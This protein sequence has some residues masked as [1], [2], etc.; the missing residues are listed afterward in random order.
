MRPLGEKLRFWGIITGGLGA[1][2]NYRIEV[3][4]KFWASVG[5]EMREMASVF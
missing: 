5:V 3:V 2:D 4:S 1:D